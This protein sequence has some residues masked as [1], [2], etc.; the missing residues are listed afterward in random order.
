MRAC[1]PYLGVAYLILCALPAQAA[2]LTKIERT[3]AKEPKYQGKPGKPKYCLLVFGPEAKFRVWLV[4]DEAVLYV[5]RN[6]NGDLTEPDKRVANRSKRDDHHSLFQP[7]QIG[8]PDGKAKYY[9]SQLWNCTEGCEMTMRLGDAGYALVGFDGPGSLQFAD[10]AQDAP[11]IH[12]LGPLTLQRFDPQ[13]GSISQHLKPQPLVRGHESRLAFSLGTP[14]LGNGTFA[15]QSYGGSQAA[16]AEI[17]FANGK[18]ITAL[19]APDG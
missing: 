14:G 16:S 5:D 7:G 6:G 4:L 17:R 11:I 10:R 8:T 12:F 3:I 13:P 1:P 15:K 9:L 18:T 2:D 19:I